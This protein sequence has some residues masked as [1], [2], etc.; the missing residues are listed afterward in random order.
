M[1]W[2]QLSFQIPENLGEDAVEQLEGAGALSVTLTAAENEEIFEPEL[3]TTPL[4]QQTWV[5]SLFKETADLKPI[6][7]QLQRNL[8]F[9]SCTLELIP[10]EDWQQNYRKSVQPICI[11]NKLWICPSWQEPTEPQKPHIIL[12]PGLAFGT[13]THPTTALCLEWLTTQIRTGDRV[14]DYGCGSGI[15]AIAALKLG[16]K[17]VWAVDHD[18]Q[19]L[20]ATRENARRNQC[21]T[22]LHTVLPMD[23]PPI[24]ADTLI[25]NILANPLIEMAAQLTQLIRSGGQ[26]ALSGILTGQVN[27]VISAYQAWINFSTPVI[28]D[29]WVRLDGIKV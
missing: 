25:A 2:Q 26:L 7:N 27:P 8:A 11:A 5:V 4:W 23:L 20:E 10:E 9:A 13:G 19:A 16:A 6:I 21:S 29:D 1:N 12:D 15:L 3:N 22:S 24:L 28:E 14:I 17:E 18:L